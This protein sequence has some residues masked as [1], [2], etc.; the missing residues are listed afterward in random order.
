MKYH[1]NF[2]SEHRLSFEI[3]DNPVAQAWT[4]IMQNKM[5][6]D[7]FGQQIVKHVFPANNGHIYHPFN[8]IVYFYDEMM[9]LGVPV[10]FNLNKNLAKYTDQDLIEFDNA[11]EYLYNKVVKH[12]YYFTYDNNTVLKRCV[13]QIKRHKEELLD[14]KFNPNENYAVVKLANAGEDDVEISVDMR[15]QYWIE[16]ARPKLVIRAWTNFDLRSLD[17]LEKRN[18]PAEL[19]NLDH[20][21]YIT[22]DH[23]ICYYENELDDAQAAK[24]MKKRRNKILEFVSKNNIDAVPGSLQHYCFVP[25]VIAYCINADDFTQEQL[26]DLF[27]TEHNITSEFEE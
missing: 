19:T 18:N 5:S 4:S 12:N 15:K 16:T 24:Y 2:D 14:T 1:I 7:Q 22:S 17:V 13:A 21:H 10:E 26:E 6:S 11:V 20:M 27:C 3:L 9:S 25:P 8:F 23:K